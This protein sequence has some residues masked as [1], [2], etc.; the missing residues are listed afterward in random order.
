MQFSINGSKENHIPIYWNGEN[1]GPSWGFQYVVKPEETYILHY[2]LEKSNL[3]FKDGV[4]QFK[5]GVIKHKHRTVN[6]YQYSQYGGIETYS[7]ETSYS[8]SL[9]PYKLGQ[10]LPKEILMQKYLDIMIKTPPSDDLLAKAWSK[11]PGNSFHEVRD[12][13]GR[14][15]GQ[16]DYNSTVKQYLHQTKRNIY[17]DR[18]KTVNSLSYV[19]TNQAFFDAVQKMTA[20]PSFRDNDVMQNVA[21]LSTE[22]EK[23]LGRNIYLNAQGLTSATSVANVQDNQKPKAQ[24]QKVDKVDEQKL[25]AEELEADIAFHNTNIA[26]YQKNLKWCKDKL[27]TETHPERKKDL[28]RRI[29]QAKSSIQGEKDRIQTLKTGV[30]VHTRTDLDDYNLKYM[31]AKSAERR[32]VDKLK[33]K[34]FKTIEGLP[35][36]KQDR[37]RASL[38]EQFKNSERMDVKQAEKVFNSAYT[39]RQSHFQAEGL[40]SDADAYTAESNKIAA[41]FVRDSAGVVFTAGTIGSGLRAASGVQEAIATAS[42][43]Q[44]LGV[45]YGITTGYIEGGP[46]EA[47]KRGIREYNMVTNAASETIDGYI[48]ALEA[49]KD[50]KEAIEAGLYKGAFNL[51]SASA[52]YVGSKIA[53]SKYCNKIRNYYNPQGKSAYSF[54]DRHRAITQA[55]LDIY[56]ARKASAKQDIDDFGKQLELWKSNKNMPSERAKVM[57]DLKLKAAKLHASYEAKMSLKAMQNSQDPALK[58]V[59]DEFT[60]TIDRVHADV[61]NDVMADFKDLGL[62]NV[63]KWKAIRNASSGNSVNMDYDIALNPRKDASGKSIQT[64]IMAPFVVGKDGKSKL[65]I[66]WKDQFD[67]NGNRIINPDT[68]FVGQWKEVPVPKGVLNDLAQKRWN[69]RF[70][71]RTG[72][73]AHA[74]FETVTYSGHAEAYKDISILK[75]GYFKIGKDDAAQASDVLQLKAWEMSNN[76]ELPPVVKFLENMR[77]I[78]KENTKRLRTYVKAKTPNKATHPKEHQKHLES[79]TYWYK[80]EKITDE[81]NAGLLDPMTADQRIRTLTGGKSIVEVTEQMASWIERV[82]KIDK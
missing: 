45:G 23:K 52:M 1:M 37:L 46:C 80:I 29:M 15:L 14:E 66:S 8:L 73:S 53:I 17:F 10:A 38:R 61:A 30:F 16:S 6:K 54:D 78:S 72:Q 76:S 77:S 18:H 40:R 32:Y 12:E 75:D 64:T 70:N 13:K 44:A 3:K 24:E 62:K 35:R 74:S 67:A 59:A 50:N 65:A 7:P 34:A 69:T 56:N 68:D 26:Y 36:D 28:E 71:K 63:G 4:I 2:I 22:I 21:F 42:Q 5:D 20:N 41:E 31:L 11:I 51:A 58:E 39:I 81:L 27:A 47:L 57:K 60:K 19:A 33:D 79:I 9:S 82:I 48:K 55:D 43:F 25:L 49:G